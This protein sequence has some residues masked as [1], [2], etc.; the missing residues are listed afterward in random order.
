MK[1][2]AKS[3]V[4]VAM[5]CISDV[6]RAA[7][8]IDQPPCPNDG[9]IP[10]MMVPNRHVA[11]AIYRAVGHALVPRN[12]KRYPIVEVEDQGD[13]W[14]VSQSDGKPSFRI[15]PVSGSHMQTVTVTA[16]GG[17]LYMDINKC[18]GAISHAAL[19]R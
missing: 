4:I 19:N 17:Q 12:F 11:E 5:V 2:M 15:T 6:A 8:Q 14:T 1:W 18:T 9:Y 10:D 16:G 3:I 7:T 13:H